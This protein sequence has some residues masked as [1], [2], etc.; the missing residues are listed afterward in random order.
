MNI[1][2]SCDDYY[3][4]Q[5]TVSI[6]SLL[7]NNKHVKDLKLFIVSLGISQGNISEIENVVNGF[8]RELTLVHFKD[9]SQGFTFEKSGRHSKTVYTKF[10]F[11]RIPGIDKI[12]YLD[13][14]TVILGSLEDFW[15]INLAQ[16][17]FGLVKT[18]NK[19]YCKRLGLP[20]GDSFYN[21]G[22]AIVNV[23]L[24][25]KDKILSRFKLIM[26]E[27]NWTPPAL[28]EGIINIACRGRITKLHPK[29]NFLSAFYMFTNHQ[30]NV[31]ARERE[32]YPEE[33][34]NAAR[35]DPVVVHYLSGWFKRPWE[36]DCTHPMKHYYTSYLRKTKWAKSKLVNKKL[37]L[38]VL[39]YKNALKVLPIEI[40]TFI[41][42]FYRKVRKE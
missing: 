2:Y 17:Y 19:N 28:S 3:V 35:K 26:E 22:V 11:E 1:C 38:N 10:F 41:V 40:L 12:I 21:D 36:V 42:D 31:F 15:N 34:V 33:I 27:Y 18:I 37:P 20:V 4:P 39:I 25:K 14:D 8:K 16:N 13:S 6:L 32:F 5:T 9:I 30:L 23:S 24:I 7:E 29:F